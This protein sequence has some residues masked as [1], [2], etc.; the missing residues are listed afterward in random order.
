MEND[1]HSPAGSCCSGQDDGWIFGVKVAQRLLGYIAQ[2]LNTFI[3]GDI[4][5]GSFIKLRFDIIS[6]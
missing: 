6:I 3:E 1:L 2:G 4:F 5:F